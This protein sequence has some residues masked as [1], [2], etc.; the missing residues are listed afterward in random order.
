MRQKRAFRWSF[1]VLWALLQAKNGSR[2][3]RHVAYNHSIDRYLPLCRGVQA[4]E[5]VV[6]FV[7]VGL[8]LL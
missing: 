3:E 4:E 2:K 8:L 5:V 6:S 1:E 7:K